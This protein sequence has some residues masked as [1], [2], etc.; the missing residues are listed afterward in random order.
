MKT[1]KFLAGIVLA[2]T[3]VAG[4]AVQAGDSTTNSPATKPIPYPLKTCPVSDEKLGADMGPAY[5]FVYQG[6][7]IKLCC[8]GCK[9]DFLKDPAKFLKKIK[10]LAAEQ[11]Q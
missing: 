6:Q 11:K 3:L 7:E 10:K 4:P 9:K 8:S 1:I 2:T 5:V